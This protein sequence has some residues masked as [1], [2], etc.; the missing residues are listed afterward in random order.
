MV[1]CAIYIFLG[2]N[3]RSSLCKRIYNPVLF[4]FLL[5]NLNGDKVVA[6]KLLSLIDLLF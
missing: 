1:N 6:Y 2:I 4:E 5:K 3:V